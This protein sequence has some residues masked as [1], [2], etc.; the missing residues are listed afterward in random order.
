MCD[1]WLVAP[2]VSWARRLQQRPQRVLRKRRRA[3]DAHAEELLA[4]LHHG[5]KYR[6]AG[7]QA[8]GLRCVERRRVLLLQ[9]LI[10]VLVQVSE[11]QV[12]L[13]LLI[14]D[15]TSAVHPRLIR[16]GQHKGRDFRDGVGGGDGGVHEA[17]AV[18]EAEHGHLGREAD[19]RPLLQ[20]QAPQHRRLEPGLQQEGA[21]RALFR[22]ARAREREA[23]AHA[24]L[25]V[26]VGDRTRVRCAGHQG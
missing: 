12:W 7:Q 15:D 17:H 25:A 23:L 20:R 8:D 1:H 4:D 16:R 21:L 22:P 9:L 2:T 10:G 14:P 26:V 19:A 11:Q 24:D 18:R 3:R 6:N 13:Q 5:V